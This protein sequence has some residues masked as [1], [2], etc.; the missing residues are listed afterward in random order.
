M[1]KQVKLWE[2]KA[3]TAEDLSA[4]LYDTFVIAHIHG[5]NWELAI[6]SLP[7]VVVPELLAYVE[8]HEPQVIAPYG[9]RDPQRRSAQDREVL[10]GQQKLI[11]RLREKSRITRQCSGPPRRQAAQ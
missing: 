6:E 7:A 10:I 2:R 9:E 4:A 11:A 8:T 5:A 1:W 3:I